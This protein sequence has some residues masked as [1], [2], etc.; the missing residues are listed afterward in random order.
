MGGPR[1]ETKKRLTIARGVSGSLENIV[2]GAMLGGSMGFG[3]NYSVTEKSDIDFVF[4]L[5]PA[6]LDRLASKWFFHDRIPV[7]VPSLFKNGDIN[8]FWVTREVTDVVVNAYIYSPRGIS[9]FCTL[10]GDLNGFI[11]QPIA[12]TQ[13][14]YGFDGKPI[15]FS[16]N[17]RQFGG[18]SV[19][20]KPALADGRYWGG[21]PRQ[22]LFYS[23]QVLLER[24]SFLS[25][26]EK[27][28]W[29]SAIAQLVAEH[30]PRPDL[31]KFSVLNTHYTYQTS[32]R[33][34]PPAVIS[35]IRARTEVE[36]KAY[37]SGT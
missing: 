26:L 10:K 15:T 31:G 18:G 30:G 14:S 2:E 35:Q 23:G 13:T 5:D 1:F 8:L 22:D 24:G 12:P 28:A 29:W 19:F 9:D 6:R 33:K 27:R 37:K 36:L 34:L 4:V 21:V 11:G 16:R 25:D 32:P 7:G 3:Q 20:S 17:V